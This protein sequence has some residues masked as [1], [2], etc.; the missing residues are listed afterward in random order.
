MRSP[1]A[2]EIGWSAQS[3]YRQISLVVLGIILCAVPGCIDRGE[4]PDQPATPS[5]PAYQAFDFRVFDSESGA[6]FSSG[7]KTKYGH[8]LDDQLE[9]DYLYIDAK[10]PLGTNPT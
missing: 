3:K 6:T 4:G 5:K 8:Q 9:A 1:L 7:C 10:V 2:P